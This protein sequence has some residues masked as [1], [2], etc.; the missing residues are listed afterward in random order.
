MRLVA[1]VSFLMSVS[2]SHAAGLNPVSPG[3]TV[4]LD[5]EQPHSSLSLQLIQ[6]E[7]D[8]ILAPVR[9]NVHLRVK[10]ELPRA[11]QFSDLVLFKMKGRCSMDA[12]PIGALSDERGPLAMTYSVDGGLLPFGEVQCD[13]VRQSLQRALG[14][15]NPATHQ[16]AFSIALARVIAHEMYHMITNSSTHTKEGVTKESLSGRELSQE[17]M[18]YPSAARNS[19]Q[20]HA[21]RA[22]VH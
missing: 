6:H 1:L 22:S 9:L 5:F 7:L 8:R 4:L 19:L 12:L 14:R 10:S 20:D 18:Y 15:A 17:P 11:P 2:L 16:T 13:R 3:I 21:G